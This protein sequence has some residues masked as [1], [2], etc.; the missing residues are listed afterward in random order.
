[1][2]GAGME[3]GESG[4]GWDA[5]KDAGHGAAAPHRPRTGSSGS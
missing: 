3:G 4:P 2:W 5:G 1:M